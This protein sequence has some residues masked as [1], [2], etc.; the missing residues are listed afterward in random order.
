MKH[1]QVY[2]KVLGVRESTTMMN[3]TCNILKELARGRYSKEV[4]H[5]SYISC[6][7]LF[8]K[9]ECNICDQ[10]KERA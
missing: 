1:N 3:G 5:V 6:S 8:S 2:S 4:V 9:I 7:F 10:F